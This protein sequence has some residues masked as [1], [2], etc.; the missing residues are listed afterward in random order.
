[1]TENFHRPAWV[2][3]DGLPEGLSL[4]ERVEELFVGIDGLTPYAISN[5]GT[6]VNIDTGNEIKSYLGKDG[7]RR[8]TIRRTTIDGVRKKYTLLVHRWV[9]MA[10][11]VNYAP[12]IEVNAING[13]YSDCSV[14][15][16]TLG[17]RHCREGDDLRG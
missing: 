15:N 1:M 12:D 3:Y 8:V 6:I 7:Y 16:L 11:F 13:D 10:F 2:D 17:E 4:R 9:A 14:L 5:Y